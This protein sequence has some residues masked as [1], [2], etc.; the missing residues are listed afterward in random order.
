MP[1]EIGDF[2]FT[3]NRVELAS[4]T[5][6]KTQKL[7]EEMLKREREKNDN[8]KHDSI[9]TSY[10]RGKIALLKELIELNKELR[11]KKDEEEE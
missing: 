11:E 10:N 7:F 4:S 6:N 2:E 9:M 1:K 3:L 8:P 5:W